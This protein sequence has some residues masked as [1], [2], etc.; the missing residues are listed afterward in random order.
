MENLQRWSA[1][2]EIVAA[3]AVVLSIIYLAIEVRGN[4]NAIE[5]QTRQGLLDAAN[6]INMGVSNDSALADLIF[7]AQEG[8]DE[9]SEVERIQYTHFINGELN[10][11]EQ[12]YYSHANDTMEDDIWIAYDMGYSGLFCYQGVKQVWR[13]INAYFGADFR[14]HVNSVAELEC[15][16]TGSATSSTS[17][18]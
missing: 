10:L 5:S 2:A 8:L 18:D 12:A 13:D 11:W 1:I 3:V 16:E 17:Q 6:A 15:A 9:I 4:T 7:R 14:G